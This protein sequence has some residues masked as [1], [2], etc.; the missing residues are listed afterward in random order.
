MN[1]PSLSKSLQM[2]WRRS[3][4]SRISYRI[5]FRGFALGG[6]SLITFTFCYT[7]ISWITSP[8]TQSVNFAEA[9]S[10]NSFL[11]TDRTDVFAIY[12]LFMALFFLIGFTAYVLDKLLLKGEVFGNAS[13]SIGLLL[14]IFMAVIAALI[15]TSTSDSFIFFT[16][17]FG[18]VVYY[19]WAI[20]EKRKVIVR[21]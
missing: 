6:A 18:T 1:Q 19:F 20:L 8:K 17:L 4:L 9:F 10:S 5:L 12:P 7:S 15:G 2:W 14:F 11:S 16:G 3:F 13:G 21:K